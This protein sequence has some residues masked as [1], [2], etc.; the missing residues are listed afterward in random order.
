MRGAVICALAVLGV[1]ALVAGTTAPT[2]AAD[3][4]VRHALFGVHDRSGASYG[5]VHEGSVRLWDVGV[6]WDMVETTPG[7]YDW[8]R[9]DSLVAGA[10]AAHT[11]VTMVVAMTPA[12]YS[13]D[14]TK[15]PRRIARYKE[16]VRALMKRYHDFHGHRGIAAYQVWNEGN[17]SAYWTGTP[18]QLASL[19]RAMWQMRNRWDPQA[20]VIAPPMAAR[21]GSQLKDL[22]DYHSRRVHR[23]PVWHYFD[24]VAL[25]LY[26]LAT[27]GDR[28]GVPED[29]MRIL[30]TVRARLHRLGVPAHEPIWATEINYGISSGIAAVLHATPISDAR[31]QANVARTYLLAA[32]NRVARVFWYRYDYRRLTPEQGGGLRANTM[33][34]DPVDP[35]VVTPAGRAYVRV[36][37]WMHGRLLAP[38]HARPCPRDRHGTY[39]CTVRDDRGVRRIYWN[40]FRRAAVRLARGAREAESITGTVQSVTGG[41]RLTV[42][43]RPVMVSR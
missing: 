5:T 10:Q 9:L 18:G 20:K 41:S 36:Q 1:L 34:S 3:V 29:S 39:T 31:Q 33:L 4:R 30:H 27:Y 8:S 23:H 28:A 7:H 25:S 32:A 37:D 16:F 21:L 6:R 26:P 12:F 19:T 14:P 15:P 22:V 24:A 42:G 11:Q 13:S 40:P 35:T 43:Y 17:I 2:V 38:R